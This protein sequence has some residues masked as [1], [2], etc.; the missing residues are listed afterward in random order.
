M[1]LTTQNKLTE[2]V[3]IAFEMAGLP[4]EEASCLV[5]WGHGWGQNRSMFRPFAEALSARAAHLLVDFPGF[6]L[7]PMP[8]QNWETADYADALAKVVEPCRSVKKIIY[9]GHSFGGRVGIQI[10]ARR[11]ELVDGLFLIGS[12]GLP[13]H[14]SLIKKLKMKC[15]VYAFKTLKHLAPLLGLDVDVL[16][17]K[18]GSADY[19][20]AG[21]LRPLFLRIISENLS[22]EAKKIKCPV[23]LIYGENDDE[24]P[25]EIG[26]R[27]AGLIPG[28]VL[29]ILPGHDHYS[30]LGEGR[31]VAIKRVA[32]F[33]EKQ[34]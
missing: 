4:L 26:E 25:P 20:T 15:R 3:N 31:H 32:D 19:R 34:K 10:A 7:S 6:G 27:L 23:Q 13:R 17:T 16:R 5:V 28:A 22:A 30:L 33:M 11:P 8:P 18:F 2:T 12:A 14:R 1:T 24:T 9:V 21:L 29:T